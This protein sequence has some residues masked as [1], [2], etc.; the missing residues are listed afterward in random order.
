VTRA[1]LWCSTWAL[2]R[3]I[4]VTGDAEGDRVQA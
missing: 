3:D 1:H 2:R 4:D